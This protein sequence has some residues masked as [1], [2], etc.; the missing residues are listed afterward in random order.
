MSSGSEK[1]TSYFVKKDS[2]GRKRLP[3][4]IGQN[5]KYAPSTSRLA[6]VNICA[7]SGL[8]LSFVEPFSFVGDQ[9]LAILVYQ[10]SNPKLPYQAWLIRK[11]AM[12]FLDFASWGRGGGFGSSCPSG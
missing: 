2:E 7:E 1:G 11:S 9:L 10:G 5:A 4:G 6:V 12:L 3:C 8:P